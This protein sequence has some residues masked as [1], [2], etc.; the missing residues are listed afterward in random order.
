MSMV[1]RISLNRR[2]PCVRARDGAATRNTQQST[3]VFCGPLRL[4]LTTC[5][6][7]RWLCTSWTST[8]I[9]SDQSRDMHAVNTWIGSGAHP[10]QPSQRNSIGCAILPAQCLTNTR[11]V[12]KHGIPIVPI[13][14]VQR[15]NGECSS[16]RGGI[17]HMCLL[18]PKLCF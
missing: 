13:T 7:V 2:R 1:A 14:L 9:A 12:L 11:S 18:D 4:Y 5:G 8:S 15:R 6:S 10:H 16:G 17:R 3:Q